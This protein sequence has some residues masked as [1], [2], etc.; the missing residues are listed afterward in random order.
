M[1]KQLLFFAHID[2]TGSLERPV[3]ENMTIENI[4]WFTPSNELIWAKTL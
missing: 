2:I 3:N 1:G 4:K